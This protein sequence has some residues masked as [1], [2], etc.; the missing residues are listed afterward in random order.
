VIHKFEKP[1]EYLGTVFQGTQ[2]VG[3]VRFRVDDSSTNMQLDVDLV[4]PD[5]EGES[6]CCTGSER[7]PVVSSK[8]YVLFH[9]SQGPGGLAVVVG[10]VGDK[11]PVFD[12]RK[13]GNGDLFA[14]TL[15]RPGSYTIEVAPGALKGSVT[16]KFPARHGKGP[17][18]PPPPVEIACSEKE[19]APSQFDI[20]A[21]QG[22]VYHVERA[23]SRIKIDLKKPD[24]GDRSRLDAST[25]FGWRKTRQP[26]SGTG[27]RRNDLHG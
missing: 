3:S 27:P 11:T 12:N 14:V 13:L 2:S 26:D 19:I 15:V 23:E 24:D 4:R 9:V 16:V 25:A 21:T 22:Q 17:F 10:R 7:E 20:V 18:V 1:G 8:G 6:G 5:R